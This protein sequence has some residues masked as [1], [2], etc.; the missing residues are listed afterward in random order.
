MSSPSHTT[1]SAQ[2]LG[3]LVPSRR[4]HVYQDLNLLLSSF[5]SSPAQDMFQVSCP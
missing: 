2:L 3:R 4:E 5:G 1:S